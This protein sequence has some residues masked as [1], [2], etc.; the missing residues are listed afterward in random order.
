V[1]AIEVAGEHALL[2]AQRA[3]VLPAQ[4]TV[5]VADLHWGK[6]ATFRAQGVPVP[7]G[8]TAADL[9]RLSEVIAESGCERLIVV[10]DMLHAKAGRHERTLDA[11]ARWRYA[12]ASLA[13]ILVRGN[14]DTR[15]GDPPEQW[16]I[17]C[18]DGP[19]LVGGLALQHHPG[20][21][22]THYVMAGHLHPHVVM[23]GRG[24]QGVRLPCF[25]FG[26]R[27]AVLPAFTG[28][29]GGGAYRPAGD[30]QLFVI[31]EGEVIAAR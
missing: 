31:V 6:S 23:R 17:A 15:A 28:F 29:T 25:A 27:G 24:R 22:A 26:R 9:T 10:G 16:R 20:E 7:P 3:V 1:L 4:S 19:L 13:M 5:I 21:H 30:D 8:V 14:H 11:I 18:V 12:H 2:S